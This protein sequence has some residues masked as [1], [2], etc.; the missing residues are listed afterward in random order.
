[1]LIILTYN[2]TECLVI[3]NSNIFKPKKILKFLKRLIKM[4]NKNNELFKK[5]KKVYS[6]Q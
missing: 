3:N 6:K 4:Y 1:M 2:L 5:F